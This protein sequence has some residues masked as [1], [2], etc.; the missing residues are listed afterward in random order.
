V[1]N[2]LNQWEIHSLQFTGSSELSPQSLFPSQ[3]RRVAGIHRPLSHLNWSSR[4]TTQSQRNSNKL[5]NKTILQNT[6]GISISVQFHYCRIHM[7]V[8]FTDKLKN[9]LDLFALIY[10][11]SPMVLKHQN[12]LARSRST[13]CFFSL[14]V[15]RC[16][17]YL[18]I[19]Y[20]WSPRDRFSQIVI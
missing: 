12:G 20:C 3:K 14:S 7:R 11:I 17:R 1:L 19:G 9:N 5:I 6:V 8:W 15:M 18:S 2:E 4:H 10:H 13:F 16:L